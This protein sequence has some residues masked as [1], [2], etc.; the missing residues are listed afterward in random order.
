[1]A[2]A[3]PAK[4]HRGC[5]KY[6]LRGTSDVREHIRRRHK[7]PNLSYCSN[8][9]LIFKGSGRFN[10]RDL[11]KAAMP[12]CKKVKD[13]PWATMEQLEKLKSEKGETNDQGSPEVRR[14]Y[15]IRDIV[16]PERT[17]QL[18]DPYHTISSEFYGHL[19]EIVE[20]FIAKEIVA[21][22]IEPTAAQIAEIVTLY[23]FLTH[24]EMHEASPGN[25]G[26]FSGDTDLV[27]TPT[28]NPGPLAYTNYAVAQHTNPTLTG[29]AAAQ[30][31][32]GNVHGHV[33]P[34]MDPQLFSFRELTAA[35]EQFDNGQEDVA[36]NPEQTPI[37]DDYVPDE[38]VL[39]LV[40]LEGP[41]YPF[42]TET[43]PR[44][45]RV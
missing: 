39:Q 5:G 14:W 7:P 31:A 43:R 10:Q 2:D 30:F 45:R 33:Q 24:A 19:E 37:L 38:N 12:P 36:V 11:H 29:H 21:P 15:K 4:R 1:M 25:D 9:W 28:V 44:R 8:C 3:G 26:G 18:D 41:F 6:K 22:G 34:P 42:G 20:S 27:P 35:E 32:D 13:S 23:N 16:C 40:D 17:G